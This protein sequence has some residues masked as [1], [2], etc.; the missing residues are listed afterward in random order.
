MIVEVFRP[1]LHSFPLR[2]F[3]DE[4]RD[5]LGDK[6]YLSLLA[7]YDLKPEHLLDRSAWI[8]L[9]FAESVLGDM[10]AA[11]QD[12]EFFERAC[13]RG[14]S[15]KYIGPLYPLLFAFG[16]PLFTYKQL[17]P[18]AGRFNKT[19][20]WEMQE[21]R[22]G[23]VRM[24]WATT[25][26]APNET[27][28]L[29]CSTRTIQLGRIPVMFG[30]APGNVAHP[31][32]VGRGDSSCVYEVT[33]QEPA[34]QR[35]AMV[36]LGVGTVL[37]GG[38]A[39]FAGAPL[40]WVGIIAAA[41]GL[42]GGTMGRNWNLRQELQ[43]R[44]HEIG[45]HN[46]ALDRVVR[47]NEERYAELLEAKAEVDKKVDERTRDLRVATEKRVQTEKLAV[48]GTLA[49]GMAHEVRN[50]ANAII[51][52]LPRVKRELAKVNA[53]AA[54]QE[55]V[56]IS[57]DCA[58]RISTIVGDLLDLGR[59]DRQEYQPW[60]PHQGLEAAIRVMG[61]R[62]N[63][64]KIERNYGFQGTIVARPAAV[65]QV[66]LNL[67]DNAFR[68]VADRADGTLN[69]TSTTESLNGV[70]GVALMVQDNGAGVPQAALERLFDPFFTTQAV[71]AGTGLGLHFS[72]RVANE[73]GGALDLVQSESGAC[74]KLWL[75]MK[76]NPP[77]V[78]QV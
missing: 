77:D 71:G 14:M 72:R 61:V 53:P 75:P 41:I 42:L 24:D 7:K 26:G 9:E 65:N 29:L 56:D 11:S 47:N 19:G 16:T 55:M 30:R 38:I 69:L 3:L 50:P 4:A 67:L 1:E 21:A 37:A 52:G 15:A 74:F 49:A 78:V 58:N 35:H 43:Q 28:T 70:E 68:A 34:A 17:A 76:A 44:A 18:A 59:S 51:N 13:L 36:G 73:H 57:I 5:T 63:G 22:K 66:F 64:V 6:A 20:R 10:I 33:W 48:L 54:V 40:V 25:P 45:A 32:C 8:S 62:T 60:D 39:L 12:P 27:T 31:K 23:F 46:T 2:A